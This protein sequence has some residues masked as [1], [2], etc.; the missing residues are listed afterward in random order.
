MNALFI[1]NPVAGRGAA[2]KRWRQLQAYLPRSSRLDAVIPASCAETRAVAAQAARAGVGRVVVVGGDGTL[3]AVASQLAFTDT[4]LGVIPAGTGN[5]FRRNC[6]LPRDLEA[7]LA[8]ALG[9]ATQRVD[10]GFEAGGRC[11]V[12][13]AGVGF[14]AEVAAAA[15]RYPS[16]LGGTLPYLLGALQTMATYRPA[17]MRVTVDDESFSGPMTLVVVANGP[18]YGGGMRVAPAASTG[19]GKLD[20][21]MAGSLGRFELLSLLRRVYTGGH[22]S[23]PKVRML[24]GQRIGVQTTGGVKIHLDGEPGGSGQAHFRVEPGALSVAMP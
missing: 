7:A 9:Q 4:S 13:A 24:R 18:Y 11:F 8:I 12:N 21:C 22:L 6:G 20:I 2:L 14:D 5:D 10:L 19:D 3:H 1:V 23:H 15:N 17:P 16:G